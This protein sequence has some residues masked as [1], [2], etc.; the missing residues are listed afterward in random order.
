[1]HNQKIFLS[2]YAFGSKVSP[3]AENR[4]LKSTIFQITAMKTSK[5]VACSLKEQVEMLGEYL[6]QHYEFRRNV[7]SDRYEVRELNDSTS[8]FRPLTPVPHYAKKAT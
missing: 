7:L 3:K 5:K 4:K 6:S 2:L 1:M 8:E